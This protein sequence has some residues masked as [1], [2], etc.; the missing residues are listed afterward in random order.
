[1]ERVRQHLLPSVCGE[2]LGP[3]GENDC[4]PDSTVLSLDLAVAAG[5]VASGAAHGYAFLEEVL[6]KLLAHE[7]G[8]SV[9]VDVV[10]Q[11]KDG[12]N[13]I[14]RLDDSRSRHVG[15]G[16][17][18]GETRIFVNNGENICVMVI[19]REG[20]FEVNTDSFKGAGGF[21]QVSPLW[22]VKMRL[23]LGTD[24][25]IPGESPDFRNGVGEVSGF[26]KVK[27]TGDP[28]VTEVRVE[29]P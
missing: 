5:V 23:A 27:K 21:D 18:K 29:S 24:S 2:A 9:R 8:A 13:T 28:R 22:P 7:G 10:G 11:P 19:G 12:K 16:N 4:P 26:Y 14:E 1:M 6:V 25:A 3:E 20:T 17:C 15:A